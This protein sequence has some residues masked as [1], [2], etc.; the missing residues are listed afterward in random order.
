MFSVKSTVLA[1]YPDLMGRMA[2]LGGLTDESQNEHK[3]AGLFN[4]S[5]EQQDRIRSLNSRWESRS[6]AS[7][8]VLWLCQLQ[9]INNKFTCTHVA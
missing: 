9:R 1:S 6:V 4:I 5:T 8:C 3:A 2:S 7:R